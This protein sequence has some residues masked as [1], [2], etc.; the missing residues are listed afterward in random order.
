M[1][2]VPTRNLFVLGLSAVIASASH[3]AM[4]TSSLNSN[5]GTATDSHVHFA[6]S[7][8]WSYTSGN[9][10]T[11]TINL[12]NNSTQDWHI[13]GFGVGLANLNINPTMSQAPN[14]F[15]ELSSNGLSFGSYGDLD[16]G[17]GFSDDDDF[18]S[19][20]DGISI[21]QSGTWKFKMHANA[22][23]LAAVTTSAVY[24]SS[25]VWDFVVRFEEESN[26]NSD[27][28]EFASSTFGVVPTP[29]AL[30]LLALAGIVSR[31][32]RA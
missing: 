25:N 1:V 3:G 5:T 21:G 14:N 31:R 32:R 23:T 28:A 11:V 9:H 8:Q 16:W 20:S 2:F 27:D 6:G 12:T 15:E 30:G 22:A 13:T 4:I 24:N 19:S 18:I 17:S 7:I 10:A 29:G 26:D